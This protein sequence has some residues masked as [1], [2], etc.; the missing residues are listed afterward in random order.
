M[1]LA[2]FSSAWMIYGEC[3][4]NPRPNILRQYTTH[5]MAGHKALDGV[6]YILMNEAFIF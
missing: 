2:F 5:E 4:T 6:G 1:I 3:H